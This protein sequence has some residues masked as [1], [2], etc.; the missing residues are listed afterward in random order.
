MLWSAVF[1][2]QYAIAR[3]FLRAATRAGPLH[4]AAG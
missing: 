2:A 4:A 3:G 1:A